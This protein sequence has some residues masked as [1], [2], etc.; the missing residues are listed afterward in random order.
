MEC[1]PLSESYLE[2]QCR[3]YISTNQLIDCINQLYNVFPSRVQS[4]IFSEICQ[5]TRVGFRLCRRLIIFDHN[6]LASA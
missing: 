2:S 3:L 1:R 4:E 6:D 5:S